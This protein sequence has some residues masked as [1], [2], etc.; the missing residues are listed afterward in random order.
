MSMNL[1]IFLPAALAI[2]TSGL[3]PAADQQLLNLVMPDAKILAG[4]NVDQAKVSPLGLYVIAQM[5]A[6]SHLQE[7]AAQTGFDPTRDLHELLLAST[8]TKPGSSL[9]LALGVFNM[10][11]INTAAKS[12]G[13]TSE[14]YKGVTI[15]EDPK[16][17]HGY[18]F[19]N[20]ALAVAGDIAS[21]KGAIDRQSAPAATLPAALMVRVNQ[22]SATEDAWGISLV[23]PPT[24]VMTH[25][26]NAPNI[27]P[28]L[29]TNVQQASGG[30]KFG[31]NIVATG[32]LQADTAQNAATLAGVLQFLVNMAQMQNQ[33]PQ[34]ASLLK[35]LMVTTN[36]NLVDVNWSI[37]ETQAE[38]LLKL[39]TQPR[40]ARPAPNRRQRR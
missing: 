8:G 27:P 1:R 20:S 11:Q 30:V 3:L 25:A 35:S 32:E 37:P 24:G 21:V 6:Q 7:L 17:A 19:V 4:V 36:M 28:T 34:A 9:T 40:I 15:V 16:Q 29:F 39:R 5:Q 33:N 18:A 13:A 38:T 22:L 14:T 26:P 2:G 12:A 23:P 31:A 10:D